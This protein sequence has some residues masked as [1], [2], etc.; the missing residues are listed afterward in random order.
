MDIV[1]QVLR[2]LNY[3]FGGAVLLVGFGAYIFSGALVP[4]LL[5]LGLAAVGP[6]EDLLM[7]YLRLSGVTP[8]QTKKL[9]DQGTSLVFVIL[10]LAAVLL[11]L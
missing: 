9:V 2:V 6:V 1:L 8:E 10:L 11:S 5:A 7:R 3:I 4:L